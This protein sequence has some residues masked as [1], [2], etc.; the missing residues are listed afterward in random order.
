MYGACKVLSVQYM[1]CTAQQKNPT[2]SSTELP[3]IDDYRRKVHDL[4]QH[5]GVNAVV[6]AY[7]VMHGQ[8]LICWTE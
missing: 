5:C 3:I 1:Y 6:R 8:W 7:P 4:L 2:D